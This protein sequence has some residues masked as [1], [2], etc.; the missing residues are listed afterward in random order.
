MAR[1]WVW[2]LRQHRWEEVINI[3]VGGTPSVTGAYRTAFTADLEPGDCV[4]WEYGVNDANYV[5]MN[6]DIE[7]FLRYI[8]HT[9][10]ACLD[11]GATFV[12]VMFQPRRHEEHPERT[13]YV[14]A[15]HDLFDHYGI[16]TF[17]L[18][19]QYRTHLGVE[20]LPP[21]FHLDP[22]HLALDPDMMSFIATRVGALIDLATPIEPAEPL[23]TGGRQLHFYAPPETGRFK[24]SMFDLPVG[25]L[26]IRFDIGE[27]ERIVAFMIVSTVFGGGVRS[28]T[29][30]QV[31]EFSATRETEIHGVKPDKVIDGPLFRLVCCEWSEASSWVAGTDDPL[32]LTW[33]DTPGEYFADIALR[34]QLDQA[35]LDGRGAL[36]VGV[37]TEGPPPSS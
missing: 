35:E 22:A 18:S 31:F 13:P 15:L 6:Y 12:P 29:R 19:E 20:T 36:L 26:P 8:E 9:V 23:H 10:R 2:T 27:G 21:E 16:P 24:N 1:G 28:A 25:T 32:E 7:I 14:Q 34:P 37:M 4:I 33:I 17:N 11:A 5:T 30:D 3:S